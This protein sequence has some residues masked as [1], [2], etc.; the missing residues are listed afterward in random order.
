ML[1]LL[2]FAFLLG[3]FAAFDVIVRTG[4]ADNPADWEASG[5]PHGFFWVPKE[6]RG[7]LGFPS[8]SAGAARTSCSFEWLLVS[9]SWVAGNRSLQIAVWLYR[10][11]IAGWLLCFIGLFVF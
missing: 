6:S 5:S 1:F 10:T 7:F 4:Y 3:A 11:L 9:P 8:L 2:A